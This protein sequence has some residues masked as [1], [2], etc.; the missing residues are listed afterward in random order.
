MSDHELTNF[1]MLL[2]EMAE[3]DRLAELSAQVREA[4]QTRD[5][6]AASE[7]FHELVIAYLERKGTT[8]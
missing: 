6:K 1:E 5:W 2:L 7:P 3:I 4:F 8:R